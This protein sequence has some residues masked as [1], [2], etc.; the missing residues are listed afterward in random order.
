MM[1]PVKDYLETCAGDGAFPGAAWAVG[2]R[3][4]F[5]MGAVGL[6]GPGLEAAGEDSLYDLASLTK[7]FVTL[8]LLRQL[9]DGLIRLEDRV[10][11]F[12]PSF[13]NFP[14]G[15][16]TL[17]RLLTHTAPLPGG[18]ML[19]RHAH[20]REDLLEAIRSIGLRRDEGV[21]YTCEAFILLGEIASAVDRMALD[22][23]I[24]LRVTAPLGM[25]ETG[26][27]PSPEKIGRIAPTEDCPWRGRMLRGE[28]HDENAA[29]MGGVSGN[30]GIFS[31]VRDMARLAAAT[32]DSLEGRGT[33]LRRPTALLMSANHTGGGG[34]NRGLG[35]MV[36]GPL[37]AAGDLMT[38]R[39]FGHT[40]FTGTSLWIDPESGLYAVLLSNRIHPRR[41]NPGIF[42]VRH[43]FHNLAILQYGRGNREFDHGLV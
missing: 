21:L 23:L 5:E 24:R 22:E 29:V 25:D 9:E 43:I 3:E 2:G 41:D 28:V 38:E 42:R 40:G 1:K 13:R 10:D 7:L 34:E 6:L 36:K 20:T 35:W 16:T 14:L 30:A 17:F 19:Y 11:Y 39:S 33:F 32:L 8:A 18:T 26:Y 4:I 37:S 31:C 12:L 27:R 15:E